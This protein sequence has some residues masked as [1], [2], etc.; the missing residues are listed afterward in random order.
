MIIYSHIAKLFEYPQGNYSTTL[1]G[2][3]AILLK[4]DVGMFEKFMQV[5]QHFETLKTEDLQEYYIKTFDVN[6]TCYLDIGYVLFGEDTK[7]GQFLLN[8]K[9]EQDKAE[10]DCGT[11]FA[12]HLPNVL[13]LLPK[14]KDLELREEI[15][16]SILIPALNQMLKNFRT[17]GNIYKVLLEILTNLLENDF[18]DSSFEAFQFQEKDSSCMG[19]YSCGMDYSLLKRKN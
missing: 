9:A 1:D 2:I 6:A 12:D 3:K 5:S 14:M 18:K 13:T 7:R 19:N 4:E 11:E 15:V 8:M 17:E 16:V 10:N